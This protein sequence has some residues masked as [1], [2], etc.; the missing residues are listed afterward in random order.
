MATASSGQG[1]SK[2]PLSGLSERPASQF[3]VALTRSVP[4]LGDGLVAA[5]PR[6]RPGAGR[7]GR[8]DRPPGG[9][10]RVSLRPDRTPGGLRCRVRPLPGGA[11]GAPGRGRPA[12]PPLQLGPQR[13][14]DGGDPRA[15]RHRPPRARRPHQRPDHRARLRPRP[16]RP[17]DVHEHGLHRPGA[18]HAPRR[19]RVR[20]RP[21][22]LRVVGAAAAARGLGLDPLAAPRERR[23]ARPQHRRGED[24]APRTPTT[25][26]TSPPSRPPPRRSGC[27]GWRRG[28]STGSPATGC[29]STSCSTTPPACA[30]AHWPAPW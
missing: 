6:P 2:H 24:G 23:V 1:V 29:A 21:V 19:D 26:T 25:P 8:R 30:S 9:P 11:S 18:G 5:P 13:A 20:P 7:P 28:C 10:G 15:R 4:G 14:A 3:F 17:A 12:R 27:S 22:R 16:D